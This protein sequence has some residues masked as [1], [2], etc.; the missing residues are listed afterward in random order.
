MNKVYEVIGMSKQ[1]L[2]QH[3]QRQQLFEKQLS[4]L[5]LAMDELREQCP[6]DKK[7]I[8]FHPE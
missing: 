4:Y 7:Q 6:W 5:V 1:A 2:H 3:I 8:K